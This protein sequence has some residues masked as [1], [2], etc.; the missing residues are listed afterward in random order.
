MCAE[1]ENNFAHMTA[2]F[3]PG[4]DIHTND[5]GRIS[6]SSF[7]LHSSAKITLGR[8]FAWLPEL[9]QQNFFQDHF[10]LSC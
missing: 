4:F 3:D 2:N 7:L 5:E 10:S 8:R 1:A 9:A 6:D